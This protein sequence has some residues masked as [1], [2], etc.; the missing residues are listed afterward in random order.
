MKINASLFMILL[1]V[2]SF[3][4]CKKDDTKPALGK[5][6]TVN[7][8]E[9]IDIQGEISIRFDKIQEDS[10]CP[11]TDDCLTRGSAIVRVIGIIDGSSFDCAMLP[12]SWKVYE[13]YEIRLLEVLPEPCDIALPIPENDYKIKVVVKK[14]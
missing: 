7:Y 4:S 5:E 14:L 11:C 10:R 12:S 6:I 8:A 2:L 3:L 9:T 13:G 1:V